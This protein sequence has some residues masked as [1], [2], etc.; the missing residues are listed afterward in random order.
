MQFLMDCST[1]LLLVAISCQVFAL[2]ELLPEFR[3]YEC[4]Q[5]PLKCKSFLEFCSMFVDCMK[6]QPSALQPVTIDQIL[7]YTFK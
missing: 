2:W 3:S 5:G 7:L 4:L 1:F 6:L